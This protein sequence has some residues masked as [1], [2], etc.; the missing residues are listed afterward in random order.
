MLGPVTSH[1]NIS[2]V[3]VFGADVIAEELLLLD[4]AMQTGYF[5]VTDSGQVS[6]LLVENRLG[7]KVFVASGVIMEGST[8][9]RASQYPVMIPSRSHDIQLSVR[10][11]EQ[12]QPVRGLT[13]FQS[14]D[15]ML[16]ASARTG[17]VDQYRTWA[18]ID[19]TI[20]SL[21]TRNSTNDYATA[22]KASSFEDYESVLVEPEKGQLGHAVAIKTGEDICFYADIFGSQQLYRKLYRRLVESVV[23]VAKTACEPE[24]PLDIKKS[25]FASFLASAGKSKLKEQ[26]LDNRLAGQVYVAEEPVAISTLAYH[27][28]TVQ[29]SVRKDAPKRPS[30]SGSPDD[31]IFG[32]PF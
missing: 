18:T 11:V 17:S 21:G 32:R 22:V 26:F 4:E 20:G 19:M 24:T 6:P 5:T 15:Q 2:V 7:V 16:V 25:T 27:G 1:K 8:Q 30:F 28:Q 29:L 3:G 13:R 31:T 9:N 14:S 10:C 12:G 23:A